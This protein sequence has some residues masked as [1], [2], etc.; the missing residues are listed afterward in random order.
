MPEVV[1]WLA[2]WAVALLLDRLLGEPHR[3]H[4]LVAFGAAAAAVEKR[5]NR[6]QRRR[7]R[8]RGALGW[9][10]LVLPPVALAVALHGWLAAL[11]PAAALLFDGAVLYLAIGWRSMEE[12][13][14]A[15]S[16]ALLEG[17]LA[18]GR[19]AVGRIVSRDTAAA[20]EPALLKAT[21]E[22]GLENSA[23]ALFASLFWYAAAGVGGVVLHRLANTLDAM[24]GYRSER[25]A[26]FGWWAARADD[27]LN[28]P[29]AQLTALGFA[30]AGGSPI[31][32]WRCWRM[33]GWAW[34]S[35]NAGSVM[36]SGAAALGI[37]LGGPARYAGVDVDRITLGRGR[38]PE[39]ADLARVFRLV[40]RTWQIWFIAVAVSGAVWLAVSGGVWP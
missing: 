25:F 6:P 12:H 16:A 31:S 27:V 21:L 23:D 19:R 29:P 7:R 14:R 40:R 3:G 1:Y 20:D 39:P 9:S 28:F 36:A 37:A 35:V 8:G 4:P 34:K 13:V 32:S 22:T 38:A 2:V 24:W 5:L 30:L 18:G 26:E 11:H 17:D 15:V 33:Q 10:L